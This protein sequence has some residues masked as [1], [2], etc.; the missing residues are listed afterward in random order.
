MI[1]KRLIISG[2]CK[3]GENHLPKIFENIKFISTLFKETRCVFSESDST[4]KT[5]ELMKN[6]NSVIPT[7]AVSLGSLSHTLPYRVQR[8][9]AGRSAYLDIVESKYSDFDLLLC[10]DLDEVNIEP[11]TEEAITSCFKFDEWDM[12]TANHGHKY[13]D[14]WALRHP[15]WMPFDCWEMY[16]HH[17]K[18]FT[19]EYAYNFF[20]GSRFIHIDENLPFI[21]VYSAFGGAAFIKI[22]SINGSRPFPFNSRGEEQA[23][24]PS[25]CSKLNGGKPK[26]YINPKFIIQRTK[27]VHVP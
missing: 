6:F 4:D 26:I 1:N 10:L 17:P 25:F 7:D 19:K 13:Y 5:F 11:I 23:D 21:Q 2:T 3:N 16:H 12:M 20:I 22:K 15:I 24:W 14:L 18:F 27:S 8:I 9:V